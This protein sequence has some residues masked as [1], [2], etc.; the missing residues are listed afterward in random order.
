MSCFCYCYFYFLLKLKLYVFCF[1]FLW[2]NNSAISATW[3]DCTSSNAEG[4]VS[5]VI[6]SPNPPV[7]GGNTT[8]IGMGSV[9]EDVNDGSWELKVYDGII[10]VL[11]DT[12][13]ICQNDV[14]NLPLNA[15]A[16]Y[17]NAVDCPLS[18]GNVNVTLVTYISD[19]APSGTIKTTLTAKDTSK[20]E[21]F[22]VEVDMTI[23]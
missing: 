20:N 10:K 19:S 15:G 21:L 16:L 2:Y 5:N 13:D 14:E 12:G 23:S 1:L 18:P 4:S 9:K 6:F 8:I 7:Y 11:D 22:C 17:Y 3:S